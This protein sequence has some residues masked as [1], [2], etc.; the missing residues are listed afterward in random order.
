[1]EDYKKAVLAALRSNP[2]ATALCQVNFV[3]NTTQY[4]E[5]ILVSNNSAQ[6]LLIYNTY[7]E[8][9]NA[10]M[11]RLIF[12]TDASLKQITMVEAEIFQKGEVNQGDL[13]N[14]VLVEDY[15]SKGRWNCTKQ[16]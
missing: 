8:I 2:N 5:D 4:V 1:M 14:P 6:P 9:D 10:T 12:T 3:F 7:Y 15:V 11:H 16:Y 13:S